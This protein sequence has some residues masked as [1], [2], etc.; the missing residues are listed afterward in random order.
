MTVSGGLRRFNIAE[1]CY[2]LGVIA[3]GHTLQI[4]HGFFDVLALKW[5]T[6][7]LALCLVG[8]ALNRL[9][10]THSKASLITVCAV[11][12]AGVG[13]QIQQHLTWWPGFNQEIG[14]PLGLFHAMVVV[15]AICV[16]AGLS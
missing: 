7:A 4:S 12:A 8:G 5:L 16:V 14:P 6:V 13:W 10:T 3:L 2:A 11:L 15:Q 9:W 1:V